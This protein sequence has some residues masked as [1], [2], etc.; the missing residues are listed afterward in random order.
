MYLSINTNAA[1]AIY[2]EVSPTDTFLQV[3]YKIQQQEG[4]PV[5]QQ[6]FTCSDLAVDDSLL[7]LEHL[8]QRAAGI[9]LHVPPRDH[10][11]LLLNHIA[12][13]EPQPSSSG[14][15]CDSAIRIEFDDVIQQ[16]HDAQR[17]MT[18]LQCDRSTVVPGTATFDSTTRT[19]TLTPATL[20][21]P[22]ALYVVAVD[23]QYVTT[24]TQL[25]SLQCSFTF[26]TC[27]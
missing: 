22:N 4:I 27:E 18:L 20:L 16:V 13:S 3:K 23:P 26:T 12:N 8:V 2:I 1:S 10:S 14:V 6:C 5:E 15:A 11:D 21:E 19:L 7:A 9:A 17:C 24:Q 25:A